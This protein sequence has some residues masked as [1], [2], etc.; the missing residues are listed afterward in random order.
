[1]GSD[2]ANQHWLAV[3]RTLQDRG[4]RVEEGWTWLV[5]SVCGYYTVP[6]D[7]FGWLIEY[8]SSSNS[9]IFHSYRDATIVDEWLQ[10]LGLYSAHRKESLSCHTFYYT[11]P[12]FTRTVPFSRLKGTED[13]LLPGSPRADSSWKITEKDLACKIDEFGLQFWIS[14]NPGYR[15]V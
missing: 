15:E 5:T 4:E 11:E 2:L 9:S 10:N 8:C 12:R 14:R 1:M 6:C 13:L 7:L 3:P